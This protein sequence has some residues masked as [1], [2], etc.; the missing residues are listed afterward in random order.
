MTEGLCDA[1]SGSA[2]AVP[3]P[4][5]RAR[6]SFG[7]KVESNPTSRFVM[8]RTDFRARIARGAARDQHTC[9]TDQSRSGTAA[10][11]ARGDECP[12][13]QARGGNWRYKEGVSAGSNSIRSRKSTRPTFRLR[14]SSI[15]SSVFRPWSASRPDRSLDE[16]L[17]RFTIS[18]PGRPWAVIDAERNECVRR[19]RPR[20]RRSARPW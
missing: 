18:K 12:F 14:A 9:R 6:T 16:R 19:P 2:A 20:R 10:R 3:L 15:T 11:H 17:E 7:A 13:R 4:F 1:I 8:R 5:L